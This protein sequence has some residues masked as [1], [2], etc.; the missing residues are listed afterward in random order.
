VPRP[1]GMVS[2]LRAEAGIQIVIHSNCHGQP[3]SQGPSASPSSCLCGL[4]LSLFRHA[5]DPGPSY[6]T[7]RPTHAREARGCGAL[8]VGFSSGRAIEAGMPWRRFLLRPSRGVGTE[9]E[10]FR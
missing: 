1:F 7:Q 3:P 6:K 5:L 2:P 10:P 4:D 8:L 9:G